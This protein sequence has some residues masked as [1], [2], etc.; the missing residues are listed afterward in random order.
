MYRAALENILGFKKSGDTL[1][2]EPCIPRDWKEFEIVYRY[3]RATYHIQV[4]NPHGVNSGTAIFELD[5]EILARNRIELVDD[6]G[7][8]KVRIV[9]GETKVEKDTAKVGQARES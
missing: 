9:L 1:S 3:K 5:G 7:T 8:H 2:I 4:E 6:E